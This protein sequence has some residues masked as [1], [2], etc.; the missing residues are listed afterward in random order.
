M[1]ILRHLWK[2]IDLC[3]SIYKEMKNNSIKTENPA[4]GKKYVTFTIWV[5]WFIL[6]CISSA[7]MCINVGKLADTRVEVGEDKRDS[8]VQINSIRV[9]FGFCIEL[10]IIPVVEE[11]REN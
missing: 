1:I 4:L 9:M 3:G 8:W 5:T 2:I 10:L 7:N 11:E 6:I